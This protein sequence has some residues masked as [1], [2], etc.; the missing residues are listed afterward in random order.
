[1]LMRPAVRPSYNTNKLIYKAA[2]EGF[3]P[4]HLSNTLRKHHIFVEWMLKV[5]KRL[6]SVEL[7]ERLIVFPTNQC[8][9][10]FT[11]NKKV[12]INSKKYSR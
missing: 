10:L 4:S 7:S 12:L 1:M 3:F 11:V 8:N 6:L 2:L 9:F 5:Q